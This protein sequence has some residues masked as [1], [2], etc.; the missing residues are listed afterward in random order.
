MAD[1]WQKTIDLYR[2]LIAKPKLTE[3]L[4][5]KP[6]FRFLHDVVVAV[7]AA[8][9]YPQGLYTEAE[10][11]SANVTD[12][13]AKIAFLD[14]IIRQ[15]EATIGEETGC[16]PSKI[17]AGLEPEATNVF[18]QGLAR[19]ATGQ[20]QRREEPPREERKKKPAEE[21]KRPK[22]AEDRK[23]EEAKKPPA[24]RPAEDQKAKE[25]AEVK[26][27]REEKRLAEEKK[28]KDEEEKRAA[29]K[30]ALEDAQAREEAKAKEEAKKKAAAKTGH[31]PKE[32]EKKRPP[33]PAPAEDEPVRVQKKGGVERPTT[34]G[35]RP[36]KVDDKVVVEDP[37]R[38][39]EGKPT[40]NIIAEGKGR[41]VEEEDDEIVKP[42]G[43]RPVGGARAGDVNAGEHGKL[44]REIM[45]QEQMAKEQ[46]R[47]D[48]PDESGLSAPE[49]KKIKIVRKGTSKVESTKP[50][51]VQ[52][53]SEDMDSLKTSIQT[54]CQSTNPLGKSMD[55]ITDDID[56]MAKE[57][58]KWKLVQKQASVQV[59]EQRKLTE[60]SL[61]QLYDRLAEIEE[62]IREKQTK[63]NHKKASILKNEMTI[64]TLLQGVV[65]NK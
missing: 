54:L 62:Q 18:L 50:K 38:P 55:F 56:S 27:R 7:L 11:D 37:K 15:V 26:R 28:R 59:E 58:E 34:A 39:A 30:R 1:Y 12:K 33:P 45:S 53:T 10:C 40:T 48:V 8:T 25:E 24:E 35:R 51:P 49:G 46:A 61:Q 32:E 13:E 31:K 64:K 4:L 43:K 57:Y 20:F 9:G 21:A 42:T 41:P 17:V 14:K 65:A 5:T 19:A 16:K 3:K 23:V 52:I 22:L 47:D 44:V 2:D 63:I 6:P 60:D 36:P 29:E